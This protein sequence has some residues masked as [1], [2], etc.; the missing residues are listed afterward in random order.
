MDMLALRRANFA[1]G[2]IEVIGGCE[3]EEMRGVEKV[4]GFIEDFF[5]LLGGC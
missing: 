4:E 5:C 1:E 2:M 3:R